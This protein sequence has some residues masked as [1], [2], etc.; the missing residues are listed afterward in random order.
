MFFQYRDRR[1]DGSSPD[2]NR[3]V[4]FAA[5]KIPRAPGRS[6]TRYAINTRRRARRTTGGQTRT[7]WMRRAREFDD[8]TSPPSRIHRRARHDPPPPR[9]AGRVRLVRRDD[10]FI[11]IVIVPRSVYGVR[12]RFF[13]NE[14]RACLTVSRRFK[15]WFI[16]LQRCTVIFDRLVKRST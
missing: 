9:S 1:R 14:T 7:V 16:L 13:G 3:R 2:P 4:V 8:R 5:K 15:L 12:D 11:V 6:A 10:C